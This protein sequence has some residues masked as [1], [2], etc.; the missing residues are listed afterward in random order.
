[1]AIAAAIRTAATA[2][3]SLIKKKKLKEGLKKAVNVTTEK[4]S[5]LKS[6]ARETA[7]K[8]KP[9]IEKAKEKIK[10]AVEK[11]KKKT[12]EIKEKATSGMMGLKEKIQPTVDKVKE[13]IQPTVDSI[14]EKVGPLA[15][16]IK[17][18]SKDFV[19]KNPMISGAIAGT[20]ATSIIAS[21]A[22]SSYVYK[23]LPDGDIEINL[24][25]DKS[26]S[27]FISPKQLSSPKDIDDIRTN[28]AV[29]ESIVTSDDP[30]SQKERFRQTV[31]YLNNKYGIHQITG[32]DLSIK[33]PKML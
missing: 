31:E 2:A 16:E 32:K 27:K 22:K 26:K 9:T 20:L 4:T 6:K 28:I 1:M 8:V 5:A 10:P 33:L 7:T 11:V 3:K 12:E 30:Q 21:S 14:K 15:K 17:T 25:G 23:K 13:K 19:N 18:K 24:L 29:L